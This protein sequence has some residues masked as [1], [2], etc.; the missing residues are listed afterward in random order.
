MNKQN[1]TSKL[2]KL[3]SVIAILGEISGKILKTTFLIGYCI[4]WF[5]KGM[6]DKV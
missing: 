4:Y 2:Q 3:L 6:C 1:N 5:I